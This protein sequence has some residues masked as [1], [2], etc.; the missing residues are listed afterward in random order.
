MG[1]PLR[2]LHHL[3]FEFRRHLLSARPDAWLGNELGTSIEKNAR[4]RG[5]TLPPYIYSEIAH[6]VMGFSLHP[7]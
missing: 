4:D 7:S 3:A 5:K 2:L 1:T 6:P